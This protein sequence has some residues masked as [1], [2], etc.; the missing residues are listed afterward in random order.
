MPVGALDGEE[1]QF[2]D[3]KEDGGRKDKLLHREP[4]QATRQRAGNPGSFDARDAQAGG[5]TPTLLSSVFVKRI[6]FL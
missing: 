1:R 5:Y 6:S 2:A 4:P 3:G